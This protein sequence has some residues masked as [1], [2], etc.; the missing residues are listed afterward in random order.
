[1]PEA[2]IS[3]LATLWSYGDI[4]LFTP[5]SRTRQFFPAYREKTVLHCR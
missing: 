1:M 2:A 4:W 5:I 3:F